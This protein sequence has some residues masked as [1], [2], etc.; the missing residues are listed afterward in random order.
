MKVVYEDGACRIDRAHE[1]DAGYDLRTPYD[2]TVVGRSGVTI[3][4]RVRVQIPKGCAGFIKSKSGLMSKYGIRVDGVIDAGYNGTI[5]VMMF[6][7]GLMDYH[8]SVG[9]KIA[10]LVLVR[11]ETPDVEPV[12]H[13]DE[14]DRGDGGFGSTGK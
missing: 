7:D 6:N 11:I 3:D 8:F 1:L 5:R 4:T 12:S 13:L 9:D 14:T 10:Q 2:V